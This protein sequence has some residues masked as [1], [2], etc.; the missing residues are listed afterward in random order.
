MNR[1]K[2]IKFIQAK[3]T[4]NVL[5]T[6]YL[7]HGIQTV[8]LTDYEL[9]ITDYCLKSDQLFSSFRTVQCDEQV[10]KQATNNPI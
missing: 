7:V 1:F 2:K 10:N 4:L 3:K 5:V 6:Y 8:I 9:W